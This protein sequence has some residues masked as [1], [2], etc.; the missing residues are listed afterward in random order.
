M[1]WAI[2]GPVSVTNEAILK[3]CT[4]WSYFGISFLGATLSVFLGERTCVARTPS[5]F[6]AHVVIAFPMSTNIEY[7]VIV[8]PALGSARYA[9]RDLCQ[10][11]SHRQA[12]DMRFQFSHFTRL[13]SRRGRNNFH[14]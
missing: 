10:R 8:F 13:V 12:N 6:D 5:L 1:I 3:S 11:P 9:T 7:L 4:P 2:A 14:V